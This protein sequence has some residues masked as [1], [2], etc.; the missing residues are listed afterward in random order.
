MANTI[1]TFEM[2]HDIPELNL[3]KG[4]FF[5]TSL[6][7]MY[8][9]AGVYGLQGKG[10]LQYAFCIEHTD[11]KIQIKELGSQ[12]AN[13]VEV[14]DFKKIVKEKILAR[15]FVDGNASTVALAELRAKLIEG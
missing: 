9:G 8:I 3:K 10:N 13:V 15:V 1:R 14:Q 4:D 6:I 12:T 2:D 7:D 11:G 5:V